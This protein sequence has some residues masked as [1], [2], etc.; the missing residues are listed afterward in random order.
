MSPAPDADPRDHLVRDALGPPLTGLQAAGAI[1]VG[2]NS[3]L[4]IG[5]MP[6]LLGAL[7]DEGRLSSAGIGQAATLELLAM[8]AATA[9]VG[10]A[11]K[12]R[13]LKLIGAAASLALAGLNLATV[14][15]NGPGL[16]ALRA[17][18][19]AV[20]GVLLWITVSM[21]AR[22]LTPERW[23]GVFF[24]AQTLAQL[25]LAVLLAIFVMPRFGA[26]GGFVALAAASLL[27]LAPALASPDAFAPLPLAPTKGRVPPSRGW[28][29]LGATAVYVA[30]IGA[31][32]L[33]LQP[34]AHQAHLS[35]GVARTAIWTSLA[36]QA[37]GGAAATVLAGRARYFAVFL[38][39]SAATVATWWVFAGASPAWLFV[40][41]NML[42]GF[43]YLFLLPFLVPMMIE[44]DPTR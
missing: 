42:G 13:R 2:I 34:L 9:A 6:A 31:V 17:G 41:A 7:A 25:L 40:G 5:V 4:V 38:V 11:V 43:S 23:A 12:P 8:G 15:G 44:A 22:T 19:G 36:A 18:A 33:Y 30:G 10:M 20:E 32:S 24:T 26:D 1:G 27:G 37:A 21:I 28:I 29:A 35:A 16:L 14:V 3:L 39:S